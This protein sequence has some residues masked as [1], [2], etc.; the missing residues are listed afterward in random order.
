MAYKLILNG[1]EYTSFMINPLTVVIV[2]HTGYKKPSTLAQEV[3]TLICTRDV[4]DPS[5]GRDTGYLDSFSQSSSDPPGQQKNK[6]KVSKIV[7][8][9]N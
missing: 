4:T 1:S 9:F 8:A 3:S 2:R 6:V 5:F 7:P